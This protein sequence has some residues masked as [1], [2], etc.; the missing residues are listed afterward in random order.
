M[1]SEINIVMNNS[2]KEVFVCSAARSG[3]TLLD[4]LLGQHPKIESLGEINFLGKSIARNEQ[5]SCGE[6]VQKCP[7]WGDVF[8]QIKREKGIDLLSQPY[9]M[10]QWDTWMDNANADFNQQTRLYLSAR[11]LRRAITKLHYVPVFHKLFSLPPK[12]EKGIQNAFY[13][14]D[15]IRKLRSADIVVDSSKEVYKAISIYLKAP[16]S[17]RLIFLSRDGRGVMYSRLYSGVRTEESPS[18]AIRQWRKY[19]AQSLPLIERWVDSRHVKYLRYEDLVA[20]PDRVMEDVFHW[21]ALECNEIPPMQRNKILHIAG[22]NDGTKAQFGNG[23]KLDE[24]WKN[25]L[26]ASELEL[27]ERLAGPLNKS[28]GYQ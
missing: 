4:M 7:V 16:E 6:L 26:S 22:G 18:Y 20:S 23:V 11:L 2:V 5:C 12:L 8:S 3:S 19:H 27:F 14:Y 28:L 13:M 24:R 17:V 10:W 15:L 21:L 9:G 25:G 1:D